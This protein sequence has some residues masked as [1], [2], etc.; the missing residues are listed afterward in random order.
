MGL[1]TSNT[2]FVTTKNWLDQGRAGEMSRLINAALVDRQFCNLLLTQPSLALAN[3][4][5]GE[6]FLLGYKDKQFLLATKSDSLADLA[7]RWVQF[8]N[9]RCS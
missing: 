8:N 9:P 3:G 4:Y 2:V 5:N 7:E 1:I 6:Q